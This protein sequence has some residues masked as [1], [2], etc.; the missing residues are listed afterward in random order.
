MKIPFTWFQAYMWTRLKP[1]ILWKHIR[2]IWTRISSP[3]LVPQ[4][5]W[6]ILRFKGPIQIFWNKRKR[7]DN[8]LCIFMKNPL[9][10]SIGKTILIWIKQNLFLKKSTTLKLL[11]LRWVTMDT[12]RPITSI[13]ITVLLLT[14]VKIFWNTLTKTRIKGALMSNLSIMAWVKL[15]TMLILFIED[16]RAILKSVSRF[17][18][19]MFTE[20]SHFIMVVR[21][22]R[23]N[24]MVWLLV[25]IIM[26]RVIVR[27][28]RVTGDAMGILR[29]TRMW[30]RGVKVYQDTLLDP[31]MIKGRIQ[32]F[33]RRDISEF[34]SSWWFWV[35]I[36]M[37]LV[38]FDKLSF[39]MNPR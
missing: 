12:S 27:S 38:K 21:I 13:L 7:W 3:I 15:I 29:W 22:G 39:Q 11:T 9:L 14:L 5:L 24:L 1:H 23:L 19:K 17:D 4:F 26:F 31:M 30:A 33:L 18:R 2:S 10:T 20:T 25:G 36:W 32:V 35:W 8:L 6:V 16:P 34:L 37:I 28:F